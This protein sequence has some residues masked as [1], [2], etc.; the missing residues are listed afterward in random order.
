MRRFGFKIAYVKTLVLLFGVILCDPSKY[1]LAQT[2]AATRQYAAAVGF[3]NQK[4]YDQ[5]IEEWQTF[6]K[7]YPT[8][9]RSDRGQHYLGTC[10]LQEK[11]YSG[12]ITAFNAVLKNPEFELLDQSMLNL[13]IA[14]YG[15]AKS[16]QKKSE[17]DNAEKAFGRMLSK[18][19]TSKHAARA[20]YYRGESLFEQDKH[21]SAA[22]AYSQLVQKFPQHELVADSLYALG[23]S[24][25]AAKLSAQATTTYTAFA[26]KFPDH[27]LITEVRMRQ[28]E[29]LF[30]RKKYKDALPVFSAV[31]KQTKFDLADVAM[32]RQARCMYEVGDVTGAAKKYWDVPRT[33]RKTKH[34]DATMLAGAKCYFLDGKYSTARSGLEK[35]AERKVPEAAEATQWLSRCYL[36]E[37]NARQAMTVADAGLRKFRDGPQRPALELVRIDAMYELPKF[38]KQAVDLYAKFAQQHPQHELASQAQYMAA[39]TA[40]ELEQHAVAAKHSKT[41]FKKYRDSE[42]AADVQFIAAESLLLTGDHQAAANEYR[43]FLKN[44][45]RHD[46]AAQAQVRLGLAMHL[47]G[48]H[49][50]AIKWLKPIASRLTDK[51]LKSEALSLMGRSHVAQDDFSLAADSLLASIQADPNRAGNDESLL[52]LA[53]TYRQ[54]GK[55]KD[56]DIQL[57]IL[58]SKF[59]KSKLLGESWFRMGESAYSDERFQ[60]AIK[61]YAVVPQKFP[62]SEFAPHAQYG[63][64]WTYFQLGEYREASTAMNELLTR[65]G[66]SKVGPKGY[67]VR[68]MAAYQLDEYSAVERDIKKYLSTEPSRTDALDAQYVLGLAQAGLENYKAAA[69]TYSA[70][71]SDGKDYAAADKAAY[72]LGWAYAELQD[73]DRAVEAFRQLATAYPKS[74]LASEALFRVGESYYAAEKFKDAAAAYQSSADKSAEGE[75]GEKSLHKLGWSYLKAEDVAAAAKA[76][77][78]Q[79]EKHP[80]GELAGDG[81]FLVGECHFRKDDWKSAQSAYLKVIRDGSSSYTAL[82]TFR[83]AECAGSLENWTASRSLHQQVLTKFPDFEMTPEARYGLGWALQN[84]N[85]FAQAMQHYEKVTEETDTETAAKARFMIGECLFAQK[86]HKDA[87]KHFLKAA[88]VYNHKEWSALAYFEA[89][90]CFEVLRDTAQARSCYEQLIKKYPSHSKV[91]DARKRLASL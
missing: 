33:F 16:S 8:D 24:Q 80:K 45:P 22:Q 23:T 84:E 88:F 62:K 41:F 65:Y 5:A 77:G 70:I 14:W 56:A 50:Q 27:S 57:R 31:A 19:P 2:E 32:L 59:P 83:A 48:D 6:L 25:E 42:L 64:G 4:L 26:T 11:K 63:L 87:A 9:P 35:V 60:D 89:A 3:Q 79:L 36:K 78:R 38:K 34:Y 76:F 90:R 44:A 55:S 49:A 13:G 51:S 53:D 20:M 40:L 58:L 69:K 68:A 52:A 72:E 81:Q 28:A 67:Y 66:D 75:I 85:Q 86:K 12:A 91:K 10:C 39:L 21:E 47:N 15:Q 18:F 37:G 74:P 71:L 43:K 73:T 17:F 46:N 1:V 61:A 29:L 7:K 30:N 82:A 54:L